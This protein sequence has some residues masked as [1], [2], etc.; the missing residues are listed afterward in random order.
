MRREHERKEQ[1][2]GWQLLVDAPLDGNLNDISGN[3]N[4]LTLV[5]GTMSYETIN[6]SQWALFRYAN[7]Q[8]QQP[9]QST[10]INSYRL[11]LDFYRA[12]SSPTICQI[13][14]GFGTAG[15]QAIKI[16]SNWGTYLAIGIEQPGHSERDEYTWGLH[17]QWSQIPQTTP[18]R[19][20]MENSDNVIT[21]ELW[22]ISDES[23]P[24]LLLSNTEATPTFANAS[25]ETLRFGA[26][27]Y[28]S[29]KRYFNGYLKRF[30][31]YTK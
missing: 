4:H 16:G 7:A 9:Q 8:L 10:Y 15:G 21:V 25:N 1:E 20:I 11:E 30:K 31:L 22:D 2:Q 5:N 23:N 18:L 12:G 28:A 6:G 13:L 26:S 29:G 14:E 19:V 27:T 17:P 24:I 3:N